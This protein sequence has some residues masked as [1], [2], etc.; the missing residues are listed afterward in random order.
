MTQSLNIVK[1]TQRIAKWNDYLSEAKIAQ[2]AIDYYNNN[3]KAY[4]LNRWSKKV[5]TDEYS[6]IKS[7]ISCYPLT[8]QIIDEIS[9]MYQNGI[10]V[11]AS[12]ND[13]INEDANKKINDLIGSTGLLP[14]LRYVNQM[15]ELT[16]SCAVIPYTYNGVLKYF[17]ITRDRFIVEQD[18]NDPTS[19]K[20]FYYNIGNTI[21]SPTLN[22]PVNRYYKITPEYT[23]EVSIDAGNG[24]ITEESVRVVNPLGYI[25]AVIFSADPS[26]TS[27][28]PDKHNPI[29]DMNNEVNDLKTDLNILIEM[30][31]FSTM[32][33]TGATD[34]RNYRYGISRFLQLK[35]ADNNDGTIGTPDAKFISPSAKI[36]EIDDII[37]NTMIRCARSFGL[38]ASAFRN[39]TSSFSSGY[40]LQLSKEDV[41]NATSTK[42]P[43]YEAKTNQLINMIIDL[44][45]RMNKSDMIIGYDRLSTSINEPSYTISPDEKIAIAQKKIE[46][47]VSS[48]VRYIMEEYG[49]GRDEAIDMYR[50]IL[51]ENSIAIETE[52]D[53]DNIT[54]K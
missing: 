43:I 47:G 37:E 20:A 8:S 38:G 6:L 22:T 31:S 25:N 18:E 39:D 16:Y 14:V 30:Q 15:V 11:S 23:Q 41:I 12:K 45:N 48:R 32:V 50:Q 46:M 44:Y 35:G 26:G 28:L 9:I 3:Q 49:I 40:Q 27:I 29:V 7:L 4:M 1:S 21:N 53:T 17:A 10:S 5:D 36:K 42:R 24:S 51:E 13:T 2:K 34:L 52:T 33:I 19:I 54:S